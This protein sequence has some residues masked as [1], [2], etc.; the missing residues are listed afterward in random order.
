MH[1]FALNLLLSSPAELEANLQAFLDSR[2][3]DDEV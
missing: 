3:Y 2:L 1:A